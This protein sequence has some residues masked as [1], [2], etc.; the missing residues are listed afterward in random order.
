[1]G[2]DFMDDLVIFLQMCGSSLESAQKIANIL[3]SAL[4]LALKDLSDDDVDRMKRL[5]VEE[6]KVLKQAIALYKR[7]KDL[8]H[9]LSQLRC[10]GKTQRTC[11]SRTCLQKLAN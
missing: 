11:A 1:M 2:D 5:T 8:I 3:D 7:Q 10:A 9:L 6:M 4:T